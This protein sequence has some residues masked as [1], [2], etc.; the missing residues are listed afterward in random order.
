MAH[1]SQPYVTVGRIIV[2]YICSLLAALRS[3]FVRS[4]LFANKLLFPACILSLMFQW[5][6]AYH[7]HGARIVPC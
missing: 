1:V 7:L 2:L 4:F 6:I 5:H 3:L